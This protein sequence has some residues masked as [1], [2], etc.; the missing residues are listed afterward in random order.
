MFSG[1]GDGTDAVLV[2]DT[3]VDLSEQVWCV[4]LAE[5]LLDYQEQ[6]PDQSSCV[7]P[8]LNRFAAPVRSLPAMKGTQW[9]SLFGYASNPTALAEA[10]SHTIERLP[11]VD[12]SVIA[13]EARAQFGSDRLGPMLH[14][15]YTKLTDDRSGTGRSKSA[16]NT[17]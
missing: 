14:E 3:S 13:Q 1:F 6:L 11:V 4:E 5:A 7:L 17:Q 2:F 9:C 10:L 8:F 16:A 15:L 12:R